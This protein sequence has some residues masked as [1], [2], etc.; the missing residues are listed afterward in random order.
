[1][2]TSTQAKEGIERH[3]LA[4]GYTRKQGQRHTYLLHPDGQARYMLTSRTVKRQKRFEWGWQN[5]SRAASLIDVA[6]R[7]GD[8]EQRSG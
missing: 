2:M 6:K 1:M 8:G 5:V 4:K 3:L 7:L